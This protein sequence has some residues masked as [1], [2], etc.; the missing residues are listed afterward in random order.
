MSTFDADKFL[1]QEYKETTDTKIIPV[2][3]GEYL[4][5]V[6]AVEAKAVEVDGEQ[7]VIMN[8]RWE[9]FDDALKEE[10]GLKKVTVRQS[11]FLDLTSE[12]SI[13][14]SKGKNRQLGL[15]REAVGQNKDGKPWAPSRLQGQSATIEVINRPDKNDPEVIYS[16]VRRV[17]SS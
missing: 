2:T 17:T 1:N 9:I 5:Q 11:L 3:P 15:L 14:M 10:L 6:E 4:A 16:D 7:R 13:D 8:I 12:G